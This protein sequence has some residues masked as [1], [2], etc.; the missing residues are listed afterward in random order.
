MHPIRS[1]FAKKVDDELKQGLEKAG[2][3]GAQKH[4]FLCI[5]PDCCKTRAG[6]ATWDYLKRRVKETGFRAMRTKAACFRICTDGPW[7]VV[8]P[9]G[10]WYSRVT[11]ER[12]ER[13]LQQHLLGGEP[14]R[15]WIAAQNGL[16]AST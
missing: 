5:G 2:I 3:A 12:I 15:E 6:E 13:I 14:V 11:P 9:E 1:R 16:S 8:Y 10:I 4:L 7:L